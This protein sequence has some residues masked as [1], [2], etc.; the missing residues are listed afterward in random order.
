MSRKADAQEDFASKT[1][2][3]QLNTKTVG[4][5]PSATGLTDDLVPDTV[6]D[7]DDFDNVKNQ[8]TL[9]LS[10]LDAL[11]VLNTIGQI[12]NTQSVSGPIPDTSLFFESSITGSGEPNGKVVFTPPK[13]QVWAI[14][15]IGVEK[16]TAGNVTY[17]VG[18]QDVTTS[19]NMFF[20]VDT[21]GGSPWAPDDEAGKMVYLDSNT[22]LYN[23]VFGTFSGSDEVLIKYNLIRVR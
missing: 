23:Y 10:N 8:V 1:I 4:I 3:D 19:D 18:L 13:G 2:L 11:N 21:T 12:T 6:F 15:A 17:Y 9:Q 14:N 20:V 5:P 22:R 16:T 7:V